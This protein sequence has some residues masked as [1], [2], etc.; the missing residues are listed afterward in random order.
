MGIYVHVGNLCP[1]TTEDTLCKAFAAGGSTVK[2]VVIVRTPQDDRSRGFGFVEVGS[3]Q[4]AE[5]AMR[6]M[7]GVEV[8]GK[9]MR[10]TS[11][12][13]VPVRSGAARLPESHASGGR[14]KSTRR[15]DGGPRRK[16]R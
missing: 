13:P 14:S 1:S 15:P 11:S 3:E 16:P 2:R 9:A 12:G 4:A 6:A 7:N 8:D 5:A 10:V